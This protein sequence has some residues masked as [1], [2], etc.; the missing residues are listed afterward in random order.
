MRCATDFDF[1]FRRGVGSLWVDRR[2][3]VPLVLVGGR[4]LSIRPFILV[5]SLSSDERTFFSRM[6]PLPDLA[7][8]IMN[9]KAGST[10][11]VRPLPL[12]TT[13]EN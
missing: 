11:A 4:L 8:L 5:E 9:T 2:Y 6:P 1:D 12:Q 3:V 10:P 7:A 13:G